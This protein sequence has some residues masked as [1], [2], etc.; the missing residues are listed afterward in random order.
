MSH[1]A[2]TV[3]VQGFYDGVGGLL[4]KE[5]AVVHVESDHLVRLFFVVL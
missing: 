2:Y 1:T 5:I 4:I 3:A